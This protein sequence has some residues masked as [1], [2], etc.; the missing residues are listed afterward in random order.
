V[1]ARLKIH[2]TPNPND[3]NFCINYVLPKGDRYKIIIYNILGEV[4][5][6]I[7][8]NGLFVGLYQRQI[9][10]N[11]TSGIYFAKIISN[12]SFSSCKFIVNK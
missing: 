2:I 9:K 10:L 8:G 4:I 3:G 6:N 11:L 7:E 5:E 1:E 12:N